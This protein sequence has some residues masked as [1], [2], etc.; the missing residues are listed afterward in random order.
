[1]RLPVAAKIALVSA[2]ATPGAGLADAAGRLA[3]LDEMDLDR[4]RLVDAQHAIVV[5]VALLDAAVLERDLALQ[6]G[7]EAEDDAAFDLRLRSCRD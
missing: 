4:R 2:G 3:A 5:E 1:M 7:G 6:R